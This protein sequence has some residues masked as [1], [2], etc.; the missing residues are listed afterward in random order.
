[1]EGGGRYIYF[2]DKGSGVALVFIGYA[3][4]VDGNAGYAGHEDNDCW[5]VK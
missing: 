2:C 4:Y 5:Y 3:K 1:M